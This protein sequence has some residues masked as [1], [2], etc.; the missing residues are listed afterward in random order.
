MFIWL[1]FSGFVPVKDN[2]SSKELCF[3]SSVH[4]KRMEN[5]EILGDA[6]GGGSFGTVY[7][8]WDRQNKCYVAIKRTNFDWYVWIQ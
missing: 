5:F 1:Q 3:G 6:I 2:H 4:V 7:K 8:A